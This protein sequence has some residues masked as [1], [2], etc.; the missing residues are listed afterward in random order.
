MAGE[1][2]AQALTLGEGRC[3]LG[4][5][6]PTLAQIWIGADTQRSFSLLQLGQC[7]SR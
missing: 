5:I 6:L 1:C 4:W 2:V 7:D 3:K